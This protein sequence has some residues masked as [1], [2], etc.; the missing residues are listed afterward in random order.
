V[1]DAMSE[2]PRYTVGNVNPGNPAKVPTGTTQ[3]QAAEESVLGKLLEEGFG[4][5]IRL[6]PDGAVPILRRAAPSYQITVEA[7]EC[8]GSWKKQFEL[9]GDE[10]EAEI[11]RQTRVEA[12]EEREATEKQA[13]ASK[14]SRILDAAAKHRED[15]SNAKVR[16]SNRITE[17]LAEDLEQ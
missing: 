11:V 8:L 10:A 7:H 17:I 14:L 4:W 16:F 9:L 6:P 15:V 3:K 12:R 13:R 5:E 1:I 2:D